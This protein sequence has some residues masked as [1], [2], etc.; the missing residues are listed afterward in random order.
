MWLSDSTVRHLRDVIELPDL[1]ETH[2]RIRE[3]VGRGGMGTVYL[4]EDARLR[5][6]V[7]LKVLNRVDPRGGLTLRM[8]QEARILA[9]LEHPSIVPVH[10]VGTLPD[11]RVFYTMKFV[12]GRRLDEVFR[13]ES[14]LP[15]LLRIFQSICDAVAFAHSQGVIH[16]DLKP[17]NVMV[18][19]FGEVLVMDWGVAKV[20]G[21]G[22]S[23]S[24]DASPGSI[25]ALLIEE[26][27]ESGTL[28]G[29]TLQGT[30]VGTPGFMAPEQLRGNIEAIDQRA[31]IYALGAIL[32][33]MLAAWSVQGT[34]G[35][36]PPKPVSHVLSKIAEKALAELASER[37]ATTRELSKDV[38]RY[39]AGLPVEAYQERVSERLG[40]WAR[41]YKT[42]I[43]LV[44]TYLVV[45]LL[46]I[47]VA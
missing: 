33:D 5:R 22:T 38:S 28:V 7:A 47:L 23:P 8:T 14:S 21:E 26:G 44:L 35:D 24:E 6:R 11:G 37:Y 29:S 32:R 42:P 3:P 27:V 40:R 41:K 12:E 36:D 17:Q 30:V 19:A 2:Y 10:D 18:G 15:A 16:R 13:E 34:Q 4:A 31:D 45:R 25:D 46:L 20:L 39:L 1:G 9:R 43:V